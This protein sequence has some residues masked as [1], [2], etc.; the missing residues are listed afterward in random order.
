MKVLRLGIILAL[1]ASC[2]GGTYYLH[3][4]GKLQPIIN[5]EKE[6]LFDTASLTGSESALKK[7]PLKESTWYWQTNLDS[8]AQALTLDPSIHN[9]TISRCAK[10]SYSCFV[11]SIDIRSPKALIE[12]GGVLRWVAGDDGG[13]IR[14]IRKEDLSLGLPIIKGLFIDKSDP[15]VIRKRVQ[16]LLHALIEQESVS[17]KR[18]REVSMQ[19]GGEIEVQFVGNK[20]PIRMSGLGSS[21]SQLRKEVL[22]AEKLFRFYGE[23]INQIASI[24]VS[25][26]RMAVVKEI[27]VLSPKNL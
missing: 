7:L 16:F 22:R 10:L 4:S 5:P 24:D 12:E 20:I 13:F 11:V 27:E 25:Y 3:T 14:R 1:S 17:S 19:P 23:R 9:A 2:F 18:I 21:W 8:I 26:P 6:I 15:E